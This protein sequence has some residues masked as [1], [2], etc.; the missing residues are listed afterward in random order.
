MKY[1][2][3]TWAIK[4]KYVFVIIIFISCIGQPSIQ[5]NGI[6]SGKFSQQA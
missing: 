5:M 4:I 1:V 6:P 2:K 3:Y